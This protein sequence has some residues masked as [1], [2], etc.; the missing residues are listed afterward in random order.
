MQAAKMQKEKRGHF[1]DAQNPGEF[2]EY[3]T[4]IA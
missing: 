1:R 4:K 3:A 2:C